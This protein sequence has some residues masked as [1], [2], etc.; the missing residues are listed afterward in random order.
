MEI[1]N[2]KLDTQK[3]VKK[4]FL[5]KVKWP[6]SWAILF[7][8]FVSI[9][10]VVFIIRGVAEQ[11]WNELGAANF[12][13]QGLFY[14][15]VICIFISLVKILVDEKPFSRTLSYCMR[16]VSV[17]YFIGA[18]LFPRLP[19]YQSSGFD[20]FSAKDFVLLDGK[21]FLFGLL[22]YVFSV[23]VKEG[24]ELQTEVDEIL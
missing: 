17:L 11:L 18:V 13:Q 2:F 8:G 22:V 4:N 16:I 9:I 15:S 12:V 10:G 14:L 24:F 19:A 7:T 1:N 5:E 23:L 3:S 6:V 21:V 20:V